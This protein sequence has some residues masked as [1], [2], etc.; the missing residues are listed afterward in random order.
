MSTVNNNP[1]VRF[2]EALADQHA[3]HCHFVVCSAVDTTTGLCAVTDT[4]GSDPIDELSYIG[5][6]PAVGDELLMMIFDG[7]SFVL[8]GSAPATEFF[9]GNLSAE[10]S[11]PAQNT[12]YPCVMDT[13]AN[14]PTTWLRG[15][16]YQRVPIAGW[17]FVSVSVSFTAGG[18]TAAGVRSGT[19]I[20]STGAVLMVGS[21]HVE[22]FSTVVSFSGALHLNLEQRVMLQASFQ[23]A[24]GAP[25]VTVA[26]TTVTYL[27]IKRD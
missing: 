16:G 7:D 6:P 11:M 2:H 24:G 15:S 13:R 12:L 5:A 10:V 26:N 19:I 21:A 27:L 22:N 3:V 14:G 18:V 23:Q 25:K 17:Y 20:D 4:S 9:A 1:L 8:G